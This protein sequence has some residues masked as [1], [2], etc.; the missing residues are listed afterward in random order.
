MA[1]RSFSPGFKRKVVEEHLIGGRRMVDL[2]RQYQLH[3]N[4]LRHWLEQYR[5]EQDTNRSAADDLSRQLREAQQRIEQLEAALGRSAMEVDFL[6]R[7]FKRVGIP[8]PNGPRS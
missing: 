4:V 6:R 7:A 1:R 5:A 3:H 2:C 8:F